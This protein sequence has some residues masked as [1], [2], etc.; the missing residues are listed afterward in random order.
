[1]I[2]FPKAAL[3]NT[4]I[5]KEKFY[6]AGSISYSLRQL[7]VSEIEKITLR[8]VIAPRT[9]NVSGGVYDEMDVIEITLKGREISKQ[10]IESIDSVIPRP[11]LFVIV[12]PGGERK[13]QISYKEP[14]AKDLHKSKIVQYYETAW[15][16]PDLTMTG[17]SVKSIYVNFIQQ[18][19][20]AFDPAKPIAE[21]VQDTKEQEKLRK[22]IDA[23]NKKISSEPNVAKKQELARERYALEKLLK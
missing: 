16:T 20:P 18:I 8:A 6:Q 15:G 10:V 21:A 19:H 2:Q 4:N 9:M 14:R 7:F 17:N 5:P 1:M 3:T 22:Q 12:R 13:Y 11:I 23:I